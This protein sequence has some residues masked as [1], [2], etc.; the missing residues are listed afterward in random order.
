[1]FAAQIHA[2]EVD[3]GDVL[4]DSDSAEDTMEAENTQDAIT[5]ESLT[6]HF[7]PFDA[8]TIGNVLQNRNDVAIMA[9]TLEDVN[10]VDMRAVIRI[11]DGNTA[12]EGL[13]EWIE[14]VAEGTQQVHRWH[15]VF[16]F[17]TE[18]T[19]PSWTGTMYSRHGSSFDGWW[20]HRRGDKSW[21]R[22]GEI[23]DEWQIAV[24]V[25][26]SSEEFDDLRDTFLSNIGGQSHLFCKDDNVPLIAS[27]ERNVTCSCEASCTKIA[28]LQCPCDG[29]KVAVCYAHL[30][31]LNKEV[32][33]TGQKMYVEV[34]GADVS[35]MDDVMN[36]DLQSDEIEDVAGSIQDGDD[37]SHGYDD[38]DNM[39]C[40]SF[41]DDGSL[42]SGHQD[43]HSDVSVHS[44]ESESNTRGILSGDDGG[45]DGIEQNIE[46]SYMTGAIDYV[47][48]ASSQGLAD[49]EIAFLREDLDLFKHDWITDPMVDYDESDSDD[50]VRDARRRIAHVAGEVETSDSI[51]TQFKVPTSNSGLVAMDVSMK[52]RSFIPLHTVLNNCGTLLVRKQSKLNGSRRQQHFLHKIAAVS[53]GQSIPLLYPEGMLFPSLFWKGAQDGGVL[54]AIPCA[55]MTQGAILK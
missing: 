9:S 15:L 24:Y 25:N 38:I 19:D 43:L 12:N 53:P 27:F 22:C 8:A 34:D 3:E 51:D 23:E 26:N 2:Q 55:C 20:K 30:G 14:T 44:K 47:D 18:V 41:V 45:C 6:V 7:G 1:M 37:D 49:H 54:G 28:K 42:S 16:I 52:D 48:D 13:S 17:L 46:P 31:R 35:V 11:N 21:H 29:C 40:D 50:S 5:P 4:L 36:H 32:Q 33:R 39:S 10:R